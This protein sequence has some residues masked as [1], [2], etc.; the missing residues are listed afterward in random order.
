MATDPESGGAPAPDT[1]MATGN[2][3]GRP[4]EVLGDGTLDAEEHAVLDELR[5][6]GGDVVV[7]DAEEDSAAVE[8]AVE[9]DAP[10]RGED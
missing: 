3:E 4:G 6:G 5:R 8:R 10:V 9:D 2:D 1:G 7:T